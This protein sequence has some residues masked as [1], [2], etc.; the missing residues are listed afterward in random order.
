[1]SIEAFERAL[2]DTLRT[3]AVIS[4]IVGDAVFV[5]RVPQLGDK[6]AIRIR[7]LNSTPLYDLSN[8][9]PQAAAAYEVICM[10]KGDSGVVACKQL[11]DACRDKLSGFCALLGDSPNQVNVQ[12]CVLAS[13]SYIY[14]QPTD[15][16]D[17]GTHNFIMD[18][19][20]IY[21]Q[22]VPAH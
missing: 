11:A 16:T 13:D 3:H 8:E 21:D 19:R 12:S 7:R 15:G 17:E 10:V 9:I 14:Q 2:Y 22:S 20:F 5:G 4:P 6:P 1:M 18:F